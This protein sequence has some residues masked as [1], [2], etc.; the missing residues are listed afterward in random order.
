MA[1]AKRTHSRGVKLDE[2][3]MLAR[4]KLVGES[5]RPAAPIDRR[6]LFSGRAE[7]IAE[8]FSI[9]AQPGQ[10]ALIYGER[11]VGKTSLAAVTA[12]ML[13]SANMLC[14]RATCDVSDDFGSVWRKALGELQ[15]QTSR[16]GVGFAS[17]LGRAGGDRGA[18]ARR[19]PRHAARRAQGARTGG[20]GTR[21]RPLHRRVRPASATRRR[22]FCSR[23][24]SR[25]CPTASRARPWC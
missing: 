10:H 15:M 6:S 8:L 25:R 16:P 3:E 11:G 7:Q 24:R 18:A 23:T 9:A 12:S 19:R 13:A 4:L 20:A 22:G 14:A 21:A 5:F 2:T 17:A 1:S